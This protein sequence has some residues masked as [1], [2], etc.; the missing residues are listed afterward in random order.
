MDDSGNSYDCRKHHDHVSDLVIATGRRVSFRVTDPAGR[1]TARSRLLIGVM[2]QS[3]YYSRAQPRGTSSPGAVAFLSVLVPATEQ[4]GIFID[5]DLRVLDTAVR[6]LPL[7]ER[8]AI[9]ALGAPGSETVI[10]LVLN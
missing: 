4:V 10:D 6:P 2:S 8:G 5:S 1:L 3:G 7:R 9:L